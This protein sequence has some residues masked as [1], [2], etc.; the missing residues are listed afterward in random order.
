MRLSQSTWRTY[1]ENPSDAEIPSHRLMIRAGLLHKAAAGIYNF[2]PLGHRVVKKIEHIV[3]EELDHIGSQ[4][5][6]MSVVTP[7][8]LWKKSGRW[9]S[10][11]EMLKFKDKRENDLCISPTNEEAVVD[12]FSSLTQSY[13]DLPV[14][15]YQINTKFRD[16]IRPRFGVMRGREFIM[17]DAYTFHMTK[18][19]L[20][21]S[22][23]DFYHAYENVLKRIGVNYVAVEADPGMMADGE[24]KTHEFQVLAQTGEDVIVCSKS[25]KANLETAKTKR[26]PLQFDNTGGPLRE[27]DTPSAKTIESLANLLKKDL[28]HC[29]KSLL[30]EAVT[31][32][33]KEIILVQLLGDDTLNE[34]KLKRILKCHHVAMLND[35]KIRELG[36][37]KGFIGA[38][39]TPLEVRIIFDIHINEKAFYVTGA[40]I[41]DKHFCNFQPSRDVPRYERGDLRMAKEG[42]ITWDGRERVELFRGIEVGHIFQLG[43]KYTESLGV[44]ILNHNGRPVFPLMGCYGMG[45]TRLA[46]AII[47]QSHDEQGIIWPKA[48]TPYHIYFVNLFKRDDASSPAEDIY[49]KLIEENIE[50]LFDDRDM[51]AGFK[52]KDADLLGIP[53]RI[54]L[55]DKT[56]KKGKKLEL[57]ERG[58]GKKILVSPEDLPSLVK[59]FYE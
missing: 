38:Y 51:R 23:Q 14:N 12:I 21:K 48:V 15:F 34:N 24:Q 27:I 58:S 55:G 8:E 31:D 19:C 40:N 7:G 49:Q 20:E 28:I 25:Y 35:E 41:E 44:S 10:M 52:F 33:K 13:K 59:K 11:K 26:I 43:N 1:K 42:D 39:R 37:V 5:I 17:K 18:D 54:V 9:T 32:G 22:Y 30:Y 16:E 53:L 50:V 29:L 57:I 36:C 56:W 46:A 4:E 6:H 45:I 3:R 47:E 2:L